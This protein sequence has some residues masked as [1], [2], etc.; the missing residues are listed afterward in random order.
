VFSISTG[1]DSKEKLHKIQR[2]T[3]QLQ[4]LIFE[5][6]QLDDNSPI[7]SCGICPYSVLHLLQILRGGGEPQVF[8]YNEMSNEIKLEFSDNAHNGELWTLEFFGWG[9]AEIRNV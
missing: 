4:R 9:F 6:T 8:T 1:F 2:I 7:E 5:G 3:I